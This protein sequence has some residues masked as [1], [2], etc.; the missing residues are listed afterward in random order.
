MVFENL[1]IKKLTTIRFEFNPDFERNS[2]VSIIEDNN[3]SREYQVFVFDLYYAKVL[4]V[5]GS[6]IISEGL[7][8]SLETWAEQVIGGIGFFIE[9]VADLDMPEKDLLIL[10]KDMQLI[11]KPIESQDMYILEVFQQGNNLPYIQNTFNLKGYQNRLAYSVFVLGQYFINQDKSIVRELAI[12]ILSMRKYYRETRPFTE[13]ISVTEA[14]HFAAEDSAEFFAGLEK[15][16]EQIER[17]E[18]SETTGMESKTGECTRCGFIGE[19]E[20]DSDFKQY[21]CKSCGWVIEKRR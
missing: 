12:H 19:L 18:E 15:E 2:I 7:K 1:F 16:W 11:N 4:Y 13:L 21:S 10:D 14:P 17:E 3:L 9:C 8:I 6:N 5:L 20:Y